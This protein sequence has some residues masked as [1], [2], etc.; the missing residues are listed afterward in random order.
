ME[1]TVGE[2]MDARGAR[3]PHMSAWRAAKRGKRDETRR[4]PPDSVIL[5]AAEDAASEIDCQSERWRTR[6]AAI[7]L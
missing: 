1:R 3:C 2:G 6:T 4:S 5:G 7:P